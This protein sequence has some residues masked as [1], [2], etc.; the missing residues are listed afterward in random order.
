MADLGCKFAQIIGP[1]NQNLH[2]YPGSQA[3]PAELTMEAD[4]SLKPQIVWMYIVE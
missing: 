1:A 2:K 4:L 3:L